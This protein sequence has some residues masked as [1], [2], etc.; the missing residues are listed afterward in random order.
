MSSTYHLDEFYLPLFWT[1]M[2]ST[3]YLAGKRRPV[4]GLKSSENLVDELYLP[5]TTSSTYHI[6]ELYLLLSVS[7]TYHVT[8]SYPQSW[9]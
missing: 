3:Y 1:S 5:L 6:D 9:P 8:E 2:S 4:F 7:S